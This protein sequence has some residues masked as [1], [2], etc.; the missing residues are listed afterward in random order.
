MAKRLLN[1]DSEFREEQL[2]LFECLLQKCIEFMRLFELQA[3]RRTL[4]LLMHLLYNSFLLPDNMDF[5]GIVQTI[6]MALEKKFLTI[7][8]DL[9]VFLPFPIEE[10]N[11]LQS[12]TQQIERVNCDILYFFDYLLLDDLFSL[13]QLLHVYISI[14]QTYKSIVSN[15]L[16]PQKPLFSESGIKKLRDNSW[17]MLHHV[18]FDFTYEIAETPIFGTFFDKYLKL[19][20]S[21]IYMN[22]MGAF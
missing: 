21:P 6:D 11:T 14:A 10:M 9:Y 8:D 1:K 12:L 13:P 19:V 5:A 20:S 15:I 7:H 4:I 17:K 2:F 18:D 3:D 16:L 22:L